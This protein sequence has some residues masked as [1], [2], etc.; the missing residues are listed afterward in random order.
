MFE[1]AHGVVLY[2]GMEK[3]RGGKATTRPKLL[4]CGTS[5]A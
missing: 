3:R 1:Y 4:T 2:G 5:A